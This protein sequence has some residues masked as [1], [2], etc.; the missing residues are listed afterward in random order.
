[1]KRRN[2]IVLLVVLLAA[3]AAMLYY[4]YRTP[5]VAP[6]VSAGGAKFI[7][8]DIENPSLRMD[9]LERIRKFQYTGQRRD[10]F[11]A[12]LPPPPPPKIDPRKVAKQPPPPPP[13]LVVPAKFFGYVADPRSGRR[14]AFFASLDGEDVF[15][16]GEGETLMNRFRLL[17]IGNSTAEVE[18]V[19]SGRRATLV[20]EEQGPPA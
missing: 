2:E 6:Q 20:L 15:I 1:M 10:I 7:S 19:A 18:E 14:R 13:P 17:R 3:L 5:A 4:S 11:N 8:L 9:R 16:V 12:S